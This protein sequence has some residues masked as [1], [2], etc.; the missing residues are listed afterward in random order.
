MVGTQPDCIVVETIS[1]PFD[2]H[3]DI[4]EN[5]SVL[6]PRDSGK[7][8]TVRGYSLVTNAHRSSVVNGGRRP[9]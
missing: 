6:L 1:E 3:S 2:Y 4:P 8:G 9:E 5:I 7:L